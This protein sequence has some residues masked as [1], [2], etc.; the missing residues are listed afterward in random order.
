MRI[1][2]SFEQAICI[3]LVISTS[4]KP[5]KSYELSQRLMV[6]DSYLKKIMRQLVTHDVV[7]SIASKNGGFILTRP[8]EDITLLDLFNA[9]EGEEAFAV[10]TSLVDKVFTTQKEVHEKEEQIMAYLNQ[11]EQEYR[12]K[13]KEISIAQIIRS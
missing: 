11:A 9:I 8:C 12:Q 10:S 7:T 6:S 1:R 13:L 3:V 4:E 5:L 2:G